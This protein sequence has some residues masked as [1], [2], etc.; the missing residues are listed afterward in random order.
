MVNNLCGG[1]S[2][3]RCDLLLP[4]GEFVFSLEDTEGE[5]G[6]NTGGL[7][8]ELRLGPGLSVSIDP[9]LPSFGAVSMK[10][11]RAALNIS[12]LA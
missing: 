7:F 3:S 11:V 6:L 9:G 12:R 8:N 4:T 10:P 2:T 1:V 5:D